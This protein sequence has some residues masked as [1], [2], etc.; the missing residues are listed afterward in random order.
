VH[1]AHSNLFL[2]ARPQ[3]TTM[4]ESPSLETSH[5]RPDSFHRD[6]AQV[7]VQAQALSQ[8]RLASSLP[9]R[10]H[11]PIRRRRGSCLEGVRAASVAHGCIVHKDA[12]LFQETLFIMTS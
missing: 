5:C 3:E 8:A 7:C 4:F 10:I 2:M 12:V 6:D 1:E 11:R 9:H